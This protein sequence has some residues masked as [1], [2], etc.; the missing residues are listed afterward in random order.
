MAKERTTELSSLKTGIGFT[1]GEVVFIHEIGEYTI[2]EYHPWKTKDGAVFVGNADDSLAFHCYL[3]K[4]DIGQSTHSLDSALAFCI[5]FKFEGANQ[6]ASNYFIK[7]IG[8]I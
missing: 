4:K 5:D 3:H 6:Q 1:W 7:M 2:V 8:G